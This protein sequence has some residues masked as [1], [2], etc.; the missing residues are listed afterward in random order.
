M[1]DWDDIERNHRGIM[2]GGFCLWCTRCD[3]DHDVE[4]EYLITVEESESER[5]VEIW[6]TEDG[7]WIKGH[8]KW[9]K[10]HGVK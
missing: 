10:E 8:E 7:L 4:C 9:K 1:I 5:S 6:N 3:G 2:A